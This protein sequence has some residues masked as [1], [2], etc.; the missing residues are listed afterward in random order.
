ML[1]D[2]LASKLGEMGMRAQEQSDVVCERANVSP[3]GARDDELHVLALWRRTAKVKPGDV[4]RASWSL[5]HLAL[6]GE[7]VQ[8]LPVLLERTVH[9]RDLRAHVVTTV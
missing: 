6:T 2:G 7:R 5:D 4:Q 9:G 8:P 1:A 3:L